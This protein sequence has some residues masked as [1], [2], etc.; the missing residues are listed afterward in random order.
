MKGICKPKDTGVIAISDWHSSISIGVNSNQRWK[1]E[2][3]DVERG[4]FDILD[5]GLIRLKYKNIGICMPRRQ[6][7][8]DWE[9]VKAE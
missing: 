1:F 8:E 7:D 5:G 2:I 3:R 6:F 4:N 9:I